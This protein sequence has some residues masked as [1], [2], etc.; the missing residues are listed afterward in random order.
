MPHRTQDSDG[1][2]ASAPESNPLLN[3]VLQENVRQ[4]AAAYFT[5]PPEEREQAVEALLR[6]ESQPPPL[7]RCSSCGRENPPSYTFCGICGARLDVTADQKIEDALRVEPGAWPEDRDSRRFSEE[8]AVV[9]PTLKLGDFS[10]F[11]SGREDYLDEETPSPRYGVYLGIVLAVMIAA[12]AYV[13][14][15]RAQT[16]PAQS[17]TQPLPAVTNQP[18]ES[19]I[20]PGVT[21]AATTSPSPALNATPNAPNLR[22]TADSSN[23]SPTSATSPGASD[24]GAAPANEGAAPAKT[25]APKLQAEPQPR[26]SRGGDVPVSSGSEEFATA[27]NYLYGTNGQ[28]RD[29]AKAVELLWRAVGQHNANASLLLS[30]LYLKGEGVPQDCNQARLLLDA[31]AMK[32]IKAAGERLRHLAAFGCQ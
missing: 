29:R 21:S 10:L 5:S 26:A 32:G 17:L 11:H 20:S 27:E 30:D 25:S 8:R 6:E 4:W 12:L 3:P 9:E 7:A 14:W 24:V 19:P 1:S 23:L 15:R 22:S 18:A 2:S 16:A 31:A 13:G 28:Q